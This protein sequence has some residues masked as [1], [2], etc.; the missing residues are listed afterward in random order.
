MDLAGPEK[1]NAAVSVDP[2]DIVDLGQLLTAPL[3]RA[4][5]AAVGHAADDTKQGAVSA[6]LRGCPVR[7]LGRGF[8][9]RS[10]LVA[11]SK[12]YGATN[13]YSP[14]PT[15]AYCTHRRPDGSGTTPSF[16][17]RGRSA[18]TDYAPQRWVCSNPARSS[19]MSRVDGTARNGAG[20]STR[21]VVGVHS[22]PQ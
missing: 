19:P 18:L 4:D 2:L 6:D 5:A 14:L 1:A 20:R 17:A 11:G 3:L 7:S 10:A 21:S 22:L 8:A 16:A 13:G 12:Y 9:S 15:R